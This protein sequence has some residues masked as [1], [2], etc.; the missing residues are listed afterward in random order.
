VPAGEVLAVREPNG[1]VWAAPVPFTPV[2]IGLRSSGGASALFYADRPLSF[3]SGTVG[4]NSAPVVVLAHYANGSFQGLERLADVPS[5]TFLLASAV[6]DDDSAAVVLSTTNGF[7][8]LGVPEFNMLVYRSAAGS[9]VLRGLEAGAAAGGTAGLAL[10]NGRA[11]VALP[12]P[13]NTQAL[14]TLFLFQDGVP[15]G[16]Q[17]V[18]G[19]VLTAL[20][21]GP[22]RHL[23]VWHPTEGYLDIGSGNVP[24][25]AQAYFLAEHGLDGRPLAATPLAGVELKAAHFGI[26]STALGTIFVRPNYNSGLEYGRINDPSY[27]FTYGG[28]L[29]NNRAIPLMSDTDGSSFWVALRHQGTVDYDITKI[30]NTYQTVLLQLRLP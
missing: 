4:S 3:P 27:L 23:S 21:L 1:Q 15:T 13:Y 12:N 10:A 28:D 17:V 14:S 24:F 20:A 11:A 26:T 6:G 25:N 18:K 5:G 2:A 22:D 16:T 8:S 30:E 7:G 19:G 9:V 29:L